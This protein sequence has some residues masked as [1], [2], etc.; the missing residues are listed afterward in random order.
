MATNQGVGAYIN[1][2]IGDTC[3][4]CGS[5]LEKLGE[6]VDIGVGMQTHI[7]SYDCRNCGMFP[8][9]SD[10]GAALDGR[11]HWDWC[12]TIKPE[13]LLEDDVL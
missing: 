10:C 9:C 8:P 2:R 7:I 12:G 4:Q 5:T 6:E 1:E 13:R 11:P 3:Y